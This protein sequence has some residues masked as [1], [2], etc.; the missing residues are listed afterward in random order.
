LGLFENFIGGSIE[1]A[2][3]RPADAEAFVADKLASK[4]VSFATVNK[5]IR[6][7]RSIFNKAITP[8]NYLAEDQNPFVR[9]KQ[10]KVTDNKK[11]YVEIGEY[12][13]LM[14]AAQESWWKTFIAVAYSSGLRLNEILHLTWKDIDFDNKHIDVTA[15][16]AYD[17]IIAW[18][19][20]GRKNRV[21]PISDE[22][23]KLLVDIQVN[24]PDGHPYIFIAPQRLEIIAKRIQK[25]QWNERS[26][27]INNMSRNFNRIRTRAR[28]DKC[29]IH[30]LRRS[31]ITNWSKK[32]PIQVTQKLAGHSSIKT[33]L[34]YYLAV[35]SEDFKAAGEVF[36]EILQGTEH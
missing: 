16:K 21:V 15:K 29:T 10:R 25:G 3:I 34:E 31:A 2:K 6:H 32:I 30:D 35:R 18:E 12:K 14:D 9:I 20:K 19:P 22:A 1:L 28:V 7:L 23:L 13:A 36:N 33:T 27:V 11:R 4:E 24:A 8:R 17:K 5:Y 26:E